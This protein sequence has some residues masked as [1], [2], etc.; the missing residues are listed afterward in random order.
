MNGSAGTIDSKRTQGWSA[1]GHTELQEGLTQAK[2][3]V[4]LP[5][6]PFREKVTHPSATC[7][8]G[9][10]PWFPPGRKGRVFSNCCWRKELECPCLDWTQGLGVWGSPSG[11]WGWSPKQEVQG[12]WLALSPLPGHEAC[13]GSRRPGR[14]TCQAPETFSAHLGNEAE[15]LAFG[16]LLQVSK[17]KQIRQVRSWQSS[18]GHSSG[19]L[20]SW[21]IQEESPRQGA[22]PDEPYF[23]RVHTASVPPGSYSANLALLIPPIGL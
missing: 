5:R 23:L 17:D 22:G 8:T 2:K 9:V 13:S 1:R 19:L 6:T 12:F 15:A 3:G 16:E 21:D 4:W 20:V 11:S 7:T 18:A 14:W 10:S